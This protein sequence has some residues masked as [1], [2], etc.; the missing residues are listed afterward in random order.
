MSRTRALRALGLMAIVIAMTTQAVLTAMP[1]D[2]SGL[3]AQADTSAVR[4]EIRRAERQQG[5][6]LTAVTIT[7]S[8][9]RI[10]LHDE[11][12]A[13]SADVVRTSLS[14]DMPGRYSI[15]AEFSSTAAARL[16]AATASH[17]GHP[18]AILLN[19]RVIAAPILRSPIDS[20][21]TITG[22]FTKAEAERIATALAGPRRAASGIRDGSTRA[23]APLRSTDPGVVLPKLLT[24]VKPVYPRPAMDAKIMGEVGLSALVTAGGAIDDV[25]VTRSLD[26]MYGLDQGAVDAVKQWTFAPATKDGQPVPVSVDL[27]VTFTLK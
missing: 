18:I 19:R 26:T 14:E 15:V 6:G 5:A 16:R 20:S 12:L 27:L 8:G 4:L 9:E 1:A 2:F 23:Q 21:A 13:G 10:F 25:R 3:A 22:N 24:Q 11:V 7:G 17:I